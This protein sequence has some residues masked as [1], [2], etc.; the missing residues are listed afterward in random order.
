VLYWLKR[1]S[2][3]TRR[4]F[5]EGL[6]RRLDVAPPGSL[7]EGMQVTWDEV[8][9]MH[10]AGIEFGSHTATHPILSNVNEAQLH[11]EVSSS[12]KSIEENIGEA[13]LSF[14]YPAGRRSRF[15]DAARQVVAQCGYR[16][17]VAYDEGLVTE[18]RFDRYAL[19]RIHVEREQSLSLFR[20]NL[21]FPNLMLGSD[22]RALAPAKA[23]SPQAS[24][25]AL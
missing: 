15:N 3:A 18:A 7:V 19:P 16:Y 9:Q 12:K 24:S 20:A 13:V 22:A 8:R 1:V 10:A 11:H 4:D 21:M 17:A 25:V 2:E 5:L 14:A 6:S 23:H